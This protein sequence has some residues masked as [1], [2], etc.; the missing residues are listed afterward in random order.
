MGVQEYENKLGNHCGNSNVPDNHFFIGSCAII[1]LA[2]GTLLYNINWYKKVN[3]TA[4]MK[5]QKL[6]LLISPEFFKN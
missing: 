1:S 3:T 4:G 6:F 2:K 5:I